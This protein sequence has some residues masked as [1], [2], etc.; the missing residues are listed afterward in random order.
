MEGQGC[1]ATAEEF[2]EAQHTI[3]HVNNCLACGY[4]FKPRTGGK[5]STRLLLLRTDETFYQ[6]DAGSSST[7]YP[8]VDRQ[9]KVLIAQDG[10]QIIIKLELG[11]LEKSSLS[12]S[13]HQNKFKA[14]VA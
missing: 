2:M 11:F 12:L 8:S 10:C 1:R 5:F 7:T 9:N 4:A 3:R 14:G 13:Y 6:R